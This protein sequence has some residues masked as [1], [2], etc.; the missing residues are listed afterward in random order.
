MKFQF[1]RPCKGKRFFLKKGKISTAIYNITL[2][3][4]LKRK[5]NINNH[6]VQLLHRHHPPS[7]PALDP[8]HHRLHKIRIIVVFG[9][10]G[11]NRQQRLVLVAH[12]EPRQGL[13]DVLAARGEV[14]QNLRAEGPVVGKTIRIA[15]TISQVRKHCARDEEGP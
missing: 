10:D 7:H 3:Y 11:N 13:V 5:K 9:I 12:S 1:Y 14:E 4:L 2:S 15:S 6:L 8:P